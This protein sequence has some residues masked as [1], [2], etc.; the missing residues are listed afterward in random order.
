ME[1]LW[2]T[3][4][5]IGQ[6]SLN[7]A[8]K[9][10][11]IVIGNS[12]AD[13]YIVRPIILPFIKKYFLETS[14]HIMSDLDAGMIAGLFNN[15]LL[16][17]FDNIVIPHPDGTKVEL[18]L[19][20]LSSNT[21]FTI[22]VKELKEL[23]QANRLKDFFTSLFDLSSR[24][25][26][27][28]K[29]DLD[30]VVSGILVF[31]LDET[32]GQ[33]Q[34]IYSEVREE[35]TLRFRTKIRIGSFLATFGYAQGDKITTIH[36]RK[37][38]TRFLRVVL[39]DFGLRFKS[40]GERKIKA[41]W[42][43]E[44]FIELEPREIIVNKR[45]NIAIK[46][47][48][49]KQE[50]PKLPGEKNDDYNTRIVDQ[51]AKEILKTMKEA[52]KTVSELTPL[53]IASH[54][55]FVPWPSFI[56]IETDLHYFH[57][58]ETAD[59]YYYTVN[60]NFSLLLTYAPD[61]VRILME[62]AKLQPLT[63]S[64][65]IYTEY[66]GS[67]ELDIDYTIHLMQKFGEFILGQKESLRFREKDKANFCFILDLSQSMARRDASICATCSA[68]KEF[69]NSFYKSTPFNSYRSKQGLS[70]D[71]NL[72]YFCGRSFYLVPSFRY[73]EFLFTIM[74]FIFKDFMKD[75][76]VGFI[77]YEFDK[78]IKERAFVTFNDYESLLYY[79]WDVS[80]R[81]NV[82]S[83]YY[84]LGRLFTEERHLTFF[85]GYNK[86]FVFIITDALAED[87]FRQVFVSL[88]S[89]E[90]VY[91]DAFTFLKKLAANQLVNFIYCMITPPGAKEEMIKQMGFRKIMSQDP[92]SNN[93]SATL[94]KIYVKELVNSDAIKPILRDVKEIHAR[95][96]QYGI[97]ATLNLV[98]KEE[99]YVLPYI[100][101]LVS[102][103]TPIKSGEMIT[104]FR[105]NP[106]PD[107]DSYTIHPLT[108]V[109][110]II[111][112]TPFLSL[113][114]KIIRYD[115]DLKP[116]K[117]SELEIGEGKM[118]PVFNQT[119]QIYAQ[120]DDFDRDFKPSPDP[121]TRNAFLRVD[122]MNV[123]VEFYQLMYHVWLLENWDKLFVTDYF[124][125]A[126][127]GELQRFV[128]IVKKRNLT[129]LHRKRIT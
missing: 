48:Q 37:E 86:K 15:Y 13:N 103:T 85:D 28:W 47:D 6:I 12:F 64:K 116:R 23:L 129:D 73:A 93:Y 59:D 3:N 81:K 87:I 98:R 43:T 113:I 65:R 83:N 49:L 32:Q 33:I 110:R 109:I 75:C 9:R 74:I 19:M 67:G 108:G 36:N 88:S 60:D 58:K 82:N 2:L 90:L 80:S 14:A 34:R 91:H 95:S 38:L 45:I 1:K 100:D 119:Y 89:K 127:T 72:C 63:R 96:Q 97:N 105:L 50:I 4:S 26:A 5:E 111:Q 39:N 124:K 8:A 7:L 68:P 25:K 54:P 120:I 123:P 11:T 22:K 57:V 107:I 115:Y 79:V 117:I 41:V 70:K 112:L 52:A 71:E 101:Y 66:D 78:E 16:E 76:L 56:A 106:V 53:T 24:L 55:K 51:A 102:M 10:T 27:T 44:G 30:D 121:G 128:E 99:G 84:T 92:F 40:L 18:S 94:L 46:R 69:S 21:K 77:D 62:L 29:I 35:D 114:K 61:F 126:L 42:K 122:G 20:S 31:A 104:D 118:I 17:S 125:L